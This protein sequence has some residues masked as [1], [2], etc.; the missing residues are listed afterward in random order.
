[1][2]FKGLRS[3]N[4]QLFA[5]GAPESGQAPSVAESLSSLFDS[6]I[7]N[8]TTDTQTPETEPAI[9]QPEPDVQ[10]QTGQA[11]D[12]VQEPDNEQQTQSIQPENQELILGKFK[13]VDELKK[14][15]A[16]LEKTL[17]KTFMERANLAKQLEE[18]KT[19]QPT[20]SQQAMQQYQQAQQ[21][22]VQ[23]P[24]EEPAQINPE[25]FLEEFY[26]DPI[27]SIQKIVAKTAEKVKAELQQ[28]YEPVLSKVEMQEA[29]RNWDRAF[30][31]FSIKYPDFNEQL[32]K[33]GEYIARNNLGNESN[34]ARIH[35]ILE[36]AYLWA[37]GSV[38]LQPI[39]TVDDLLKNEEVINKILANPDI[40]QRIINQ[41]MANIQ[42][43][44]PPQVISEPGGAQPASVPERPKT[45][46]DAAKLVGEIF[47]GHFGK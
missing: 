3:I 13:S 2:S 31:E 46:K 27:N 39:P 36:D 38:A 28:K 30:A 43:K 7:G 5:E 6:A 17:T 26:K 12:E 34:P 8:D 23:Q 40:Q 37:K 29:Q 42:S 32:D 20:I 1:M 18:L 24:K 45:F 9:A 4:L 22:Q 33:M 35:Q 10:Q 16:N 11:Q 47:D 15:Y 41:H 44:Q 21:P 25:E 19:K 14:A